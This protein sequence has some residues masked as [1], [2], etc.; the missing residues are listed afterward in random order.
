MRA[1]R[2]LPLPIIILEVVGIILLAMAYFSIN[3]YVSLPV[4]LSTSIDS[5]V[6]IVGGVL[7]MLPA[8]VLLVLGAVT[9]LNP[10][11]SDKRAEKASKKDIK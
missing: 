7:L 8:A 5:V 4:L 6:M 1:R 2:T 11:L 9:Q 3:G 10:L